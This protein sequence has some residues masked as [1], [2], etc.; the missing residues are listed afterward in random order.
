MMK[1]NVKL[2]KN[3]PKQHVRWGFG[4]AEVDVKRLLSYFVSY[5]MWMDSHPYFPIISAQKFFK[6]TNY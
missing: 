2:K 4:R 1:I 6:L 3:I 5:K